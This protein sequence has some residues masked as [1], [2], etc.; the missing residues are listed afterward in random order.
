LFGGS[1]YEL[2]IEGNAKKLEKLLQILPGVSMVEIVEN[3]ELPPNRSLLRIT[4]AP[5]AEP[6]RDIA[7]VAIGAGMGIHE[8]RRT[9]ATLEDIFL[10]L[11]MREQPLEQSNDEVDESD[12]ITATPSGGE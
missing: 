9:R 10:E 11:T 4:S 1:G 5:D 2:E 12:A 8:M 3:H 7:S 6:G